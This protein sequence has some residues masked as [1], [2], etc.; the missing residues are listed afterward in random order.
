MEKKDNTKKEHKFKIHYIFLIIALISFLV[1]LVFELLNFDSFLNFIPKLMGIIFILLFL[2]CFII[3]S[4]KNK[5]RH[6][7]IIFG[8]ILITIY[9]IFNVLLINNIITLPSD[10][11]VPN[12]Y[13]KT[14]LE[15]NEWKTKNNI[16]VIESYEYS[17]T[18]LKYHIISQDITYPKL[19]K[20]ID[21]LNVIIS[22]GPD[23]EKQ[24]IVPNFIG[25]NYEDVI[26]YIEDN[27]LSNVIFNYQGDDKNVDKIIAQEGIGTMHRN[28]KIVLT[29]ATKEE[30]QEI[31]IIDLTNKSQIYASSWLEKNG[32]K[33]IIKEEYSDNILKG[34]VINQSIVNE[35]KNP[36]E[37]EITLTISK[38]KMLLA[39]DIKAMNQEEI[40]QWIMDNNLKVSYQEEY[41]EEIALGEIV[42]AT[43]KENDIITIGDEIILT[44]SKGKLLMIKI[45]SISDFINW[46]ETNNID[47]QINYETSETIKKDG[48]I[49]CSH[50][51]GD[52][53]KEDDTIILTVSSGKN[54]SIPNF[55]GMS[56]TNIQTKCTELNL[57]CSF[58]TGSYSETVQ[59]DKA[60]LQSKKAGTNVAEGTSLIITLS[61]GIIEKVN[62][63]SF[64][65]KTKSEIQ[66]QC[67]S[68]GITCNFKYQSGYSNTAKDTCT[69]QSNKGNLN[70]GS[71]ITITLSNGP[72]KT[73]NIIIDANQLTSGNPSATKATLETKLKNACPGV[74]F[75]F[76][77]E[78]ANSGIGYLSPNSDVKV[79]SNQLVQGK[80]YN[81][82]INS[83]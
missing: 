71:T 20:D 83:N 8:S 32:F 66:T 74:N 80:T 52:T 54:I 58:K 45:N 64:V 81:V 35:I 50:N 19:T 77:Y 11:F 62:V 13:D 9:S 33:V 3:I 57:N 36:Q 72:A 55:I 6:L 17:D 40:N 63:P 22:L 2:I 15:L 46:A 59:K 44:I 73:Y 26:K 5:D 7:T 24:V 31:K 47:Y 41:N 25:L 28:D 69:S 82:I 79:G 78:K 42:D 23:M 27:Y 12:F 49:N 48:I 43:I 53:I 14:I 56:K 34:N 10:E 16:N 29:I 1:Y 51:E 18:L 68:L 75:N 67:K 38:G 76:K 4:I 30:F 21:T 70:K 39:P 37:E 65:G 61:A 60:I